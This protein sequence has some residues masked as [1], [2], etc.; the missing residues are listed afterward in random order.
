MKVKIITILIC[1]LMLSTFATAF[2]SEKTQIEPPNNETTNRD[3]SHNILGEYFTMTT[4]V[5][6]KYAHAALKDLYK[7]DYHP[8]YYITYVYNKNSHSKQRKTELGISASPTVAWDGG[9]DSDI[10][11]TSNE[12]EKT[13]FNESIIECGNRN[14]KDI[15]LNLNVEWLGAVNNEPEDGETG[16]PIEQKMKWTIS[17]MDIDVEIV[18][19]ETSQYNGHLHVQ[20]TEINSSWYVDKWGLPYTFEFKDYAY[21]SDV[22]INA[23]DSWDQTIN[24]DGTEHDDGEDP[25]NY[26]DDLTQDNVMVIASA[27]DKDNEKYVDEVAGVVAGFDTDPKR[28]DLY[29]GNINPPP[30]VLENTTI[31]EY[32]LHDGLN[33]SE[34]YYWKVDVRNDKGEMDYGDIWSFT[35]R[36]NNPPN[37][38]SSPQ[39]WNESIDQSIK[40]NLSWTGGDPDGDDVTYDVYFGDHPLNMI[41]YESNQTE[42]WWETPLLDFNKKYYWQIVAWE[43][44]GLTTTGDVWNFRTEANLPPDKATDPFPEDGD[45]AVPEEGVVLKW[46]GSDPNIGDTIKFDVYFD[47]VNPPLT[48][49]ATNISENYFE[50]TYTLTKYK[51]YC[52]RID[53]WD[54][55]GE[56]TEGDV[57]CFTTGENHP[58]TNPEVTGPSQGKAGV[59]HEFTFVSEDSDGHDIRYR[60]R[61]DDGGAED[62]TDYY[63]SGVEVKL[64]HTWS[65][66]GQKDIQVKAYDIYNE[67][68]EWVTF[69]FTS[70]RNRMVVLLEW[71]FDRFPILERLFDLL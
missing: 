39:P 62:N 10:G 64:S 17:E 26:F 15:D 52:W 51:T 36:G 71:L 40:S 16:V 35:T 48:K 28:F 12:T 1:T 31:T 3:Y 70:P 47:D 25:P 61:W 6:C 42:T 58:P 68:S 54:S 34:T 14:V 23:G 19:H 32:S 24:W 59:E 11:G 21:N 53:T 55:Q 5:P 43:E 63:P 27:F 8:F 2:S 33:F 9:Y 30:L 57:W 67:D 38:P 65:T 29:F 22:T 13:R 7:N 44:Y 41:Q 69:T 60:V 18:N 66:T 4:C 45:P 37:M 56:K 49:R 20:V 50:V 46:N